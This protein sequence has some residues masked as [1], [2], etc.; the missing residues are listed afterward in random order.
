MVAKSLVD[1]KLSGKVD[2][3]DLVEGTLAYGV[4]GQPIFWRNVRRQAAIMVEAHSG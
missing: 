2:V 1:A 4:S 3:S